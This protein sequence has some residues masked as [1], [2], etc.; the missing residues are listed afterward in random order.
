ME[1]RPES[2]MACNGVLDMKILSFI[3][4]SYNCEKFLEK[5]VS[6]MLHPEILERLEIIIVNDGSTDSTEA[7]A[8]ALCS[9][10]P[11]VI[12]LINQ[13]NR[14]HGG[15][16][17]AGCAAA[18]GKYLKVIDADDWVETDNLPSYVD[19]LE[20]CDSD[21]VLTHHDTIHI[22][23][24]E[25]KNWKTYPE[26]FEKSCSFDEIMSNWKSFDRSLTF[27]GITY[28]RE[29]YQT[30]GI[31][32]SEHVFYE[33]HEYAT[34][35]C[36]YASQVVPLDLL[37]YHYR[38]GD[39]TQSV[40]DENQLKR[41]G[42]TETV[43]KRMI[44]EFEKL[45]LPQESAGRVYVCRK[46]QG[47]LLSYLTTAMLVDRNRKQGRQRGETMMQLFREKLPGAWEMAKKQYTIFCLLNRLH[48]SKKTFE[49][50]LH[51]GLYNSLR[52]NHD[53][54]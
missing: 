24:G 39:V 37:I 3:I 15:A 30:R 32:L 52:R 40:S 27:H 44:S 49:K 5:C 17:N 28:R 8:T 53:F 1:N 19:F 31:R 33:D 51:S 54:D 23:T 46:A 22:G 50:V 18:M 48:I 47:L 34:F 7:I 36:C 16:L 4:P 6:S 38:I 41:L 12:R 10:Y 42:H 2:N 21:V 26:E 13:E 20:Q 9:R 29:F 43:M 11:E 45:E 35:P 14:G 25:V